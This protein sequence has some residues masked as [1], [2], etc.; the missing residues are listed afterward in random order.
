VQQPRLV[1]SDVDGTLLLAGWVPTEPTRAVV[2][3]VLAGG[4]PFALVTGWEPYWVPPVSSYLPG[5]THAVCTN[6]AVRYDVATDRV[7]S[8]VTL[9]PEQLVE[10]DAL[11]RDA[12]P[13]C[14]LVAERVGERALDERAVPRMER[15]HQPG[16]VDEFIREPRALLLSEPATRLLIRHPTLTSEKML[17]V[18]REWVGTYAALTFSNPDGLL[19]ASAGTSKATGLAELGI[20]PAD[21]VA[22]GDMPNDVDM[23]R[24]A[25]HGVTMGNAHPSVVSVADEVTA[26]NTEDGVALVLERWF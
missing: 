26:P 18:L 20:A 1:A 8:S 10:L 17:A 16:W 9:S 6:G 19:E 2:A 21:V 14:W 25:G 24:W 7:L 13:G 3:R 12:L 23:L 11:A 4:T 5:L 15:G 22:F